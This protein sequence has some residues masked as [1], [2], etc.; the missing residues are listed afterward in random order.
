MHRVHQGSD[1][2]ES[3]T[4]IGTE[5]LAKKDAPPTEADGAEPYAFAYPSKPATL[6]S[7]THVLLD[8]L[9]DIEHSTTR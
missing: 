1:I 2:G 4:C 6:R 9:R 7:D 5:T 3:R 8:K